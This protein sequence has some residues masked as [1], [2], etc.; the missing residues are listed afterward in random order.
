LRKV[1][2]Q[3]RVLAQDIH[4]KKPRLT[5]M[6]I[7]REW[8]TPLTIGAFILMACT[9]L[10]M[11]FHASM[12]LNKEVHQWLGWAL[13]GGVMAHV[14]ANFSS[15]RRYLSKPQAWLVAGTFV[16]ILVVSFFIQEEEDGGSPAKRA[17]QAVLAAPLSAIAPLAHTT[18]PALVDRLTRAGFKVTSS[19][20]SLTSI[21]GPQRAPQM[22]A[23]A[24]IFNDKP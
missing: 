23:L 1:Q 10:L 22:K 4:H 15:F 9:G 18:A 21:T 24:V 20:Q 16:L 5:Q 13:V 6:N 11:F 14:W 2:E 19:D 7:S 17:S 3:I 12:G 8:A